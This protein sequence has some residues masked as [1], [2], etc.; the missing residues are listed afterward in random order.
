MIYIHDEGK[1]KTF[2]EDTKMKEKVEN[3][4][5]EMKKQTIGVEVEMNSITRKKSGKSRRGILRY[6]SL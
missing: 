6:K 3:Q 4:I 2:K 1:K 5:E